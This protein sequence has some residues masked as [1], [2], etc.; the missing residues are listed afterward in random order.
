MRTAVAKLGRYAVAAAITVLAAPASA[1]ADSFVITS[2]V[3]HFNRF[4]NATLTFSATAPPD[5]SV[6][7][8]LGGVDTRGYNPPYFCTGEP[9]AGQT[10]DLSASD[11]LTRTP[12]SNNNVVGGIF[13]L[14]GNMY[15]VDGIDYSIVAGSI[16]APS[17]GPGPATWFLFSAAVTGKTTTGLSGSLELTGGGTARTQWSS[18]RG[19]MA[20]NYFFE[21]PA[22]VPEPAS[23]LLIGTGLAALGGL[24]RRLR[25]AARKE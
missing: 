9:C 3:F 25:G 5:L 2:G 1:L 13:Q 12:D 15:V 24:R 19:W 8:H 14:G 11:S 7:I 21:D 22:A 18:E 23:L 10:F 17:S 4:D 16:V 6:G 20:T